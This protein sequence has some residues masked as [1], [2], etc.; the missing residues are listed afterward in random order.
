M[1][2]FLFVCFSVF[3]VF[4]FERD[5]IRTELKML[6]VNIKLFYSSPCHL[7]LSSVMKNCFTKIHPT[8][9]S[10]TVYPSLSATGS[11]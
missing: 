11:K 6:V 10:L 8:F 7:L 9:S 4:F 3:L 2:G 5:I 1:M